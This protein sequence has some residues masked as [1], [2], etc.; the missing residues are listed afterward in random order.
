MKQC[1]HFRCTAQR[2][3]VKTKAISSTASS[4]R[5]ILAT[6]FS[7]ECTDADEILH[8]TFNQIAQSRT[9]RYP[10]RVFNGTVPSKGRFESYHRLNCEKAPYDNLS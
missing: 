10:R 2:T 6:N 8:M 5:Y 4:S 7:S 3:W 1:F 9:I